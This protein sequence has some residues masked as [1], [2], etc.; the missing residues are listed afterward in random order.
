MI[1]NREQGTGNREQGTG[2]REQGT[3]NREQGTGNREDETRIVTHVASCMPH[4]IPA[5]LHLP[6]AYFYG[7]CYT[8]KTVE[9]YN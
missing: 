7:V 1:G 9:F 2:N 3:G 8:A 5:P 6:Y 4:S